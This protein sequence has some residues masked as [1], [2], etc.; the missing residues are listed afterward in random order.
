MS[1]GGETPLITACDYEAPLGVVKLLIERGAKV[2]ASSEVEHA[3][4]APR[5]KL[6]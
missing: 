5:A 6:T 3:L 4:D 2:D 1:Q